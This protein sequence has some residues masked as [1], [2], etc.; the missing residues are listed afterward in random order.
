MAYTTSSFSNASDSVRDQIRQSFFNASTNAMD[1]F[2]RRGHFTVYEYR[3][4]GH[5]LT[6]H[7]LSSDDA[8]DFA[9]QF[10]KSSSKVYIFSTTCED[11]LEPRGSSKG[12]SHTHTHAGEVKMDSIEGLVEYD[13]EEDSDF[14][15]S[16]FSGTDSSEDDTDSETGDELDYDLSDMFFSPHGKGLLLIPPS[17]HEFYGQKYF[18]EGW[19][20][21][22]HN[23]WFFKSEHEDS[24]LEMGAIKATPKSS[25]HSKHSGSSK[26]SKSSKHSG[27]SKSSKHSKTL[28]GMTFTKYGKG[29]ILTTDETDSRYGT[30]YLLSD[31]SDGGFW[32]GNGNG[33]FFRKCHFDLLKELGAQYI[34]SESNYETSDNVLDIKPNLKKYG[35]GYLLKADSNFKYTGEEMNYFENGWYVP[36]KNGWFFKIPA[37]KAFMKKYNM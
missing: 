15:P 2:S 11:V 34:K 14:D 29:Y 20:M 5:L 37:A 18:L 1:I 35:K 22:K 7:F 6:N 28:S 30:K 8:F 27:S 25:K 4:D 16:N 19:W 10:C 3:H 24:L 26:S 13:S 23:G 31:V 21:P 9:N 32:N 33:W 17:N 36:S 12:H